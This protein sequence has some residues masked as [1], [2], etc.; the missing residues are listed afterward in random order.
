MTDALWTSDFVIAGR[1]LT[2]K[3]T[4]ASVV[5]DREILAAFA[6]WFA[7]Y[8]PVRARA[9]ALA[10]TGRRGPS[11]WFAPDRP[12]PWY[13]VWLATA[14]AGARIARSPNDADAAFYFEDAT[15]GRPPTPA[16]RRR[17]NF[18]CLDVSKSRVAAVF[19][20][21][22]GYPLALDPTRHEGWAVEKSEANGVH[23]GRIVAC[24]RPAAPARVYQRLVGNL[25]NGEAVDLRTPFV[26]GRPVV[27]FVKRRPAASRFANANTAVALAEPEA[28]FSAA[29]IERLTA[30]ARA[31]KLDWGG[32]DILRDGPTGRLYVVDVNKTDMPP[33]VLP[34]RDKLRAVSRLAAAL[35]ELITNEETPS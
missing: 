17:I 24:P 26:G 4:G 3:K 28:V 10:L 8:A 12:R 29:E 16:V 33:I 2:V 31:M 13:L 21:V 18:E 32:L 35:T 14:W 34:W 22:F 30:F 5:V 27:V 6:R 11:I 9:A 1:T 19:E 7:L 23:D 25:E 20:E 15:C